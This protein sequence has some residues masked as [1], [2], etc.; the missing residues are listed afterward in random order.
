MIKYEL[1][2]GST[3]KGYYL[4]ENDDEDLKRYKDFKFY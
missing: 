1:P 2:F 4:R 3:N